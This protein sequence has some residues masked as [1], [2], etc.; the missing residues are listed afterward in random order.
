MREEGAPESDLEE[1]IAE[2]LRLTPSFETT[3]V[4]GNAENEPAPAKARRSIRR[5]FYSLQRAKSSTKKLE[6]AL[7]VVIATV[8]AALSAIESPLYEAAAIGTATYF[9][10]HATLKFAKSDRIIKQQNLAITLARPAAVRFNDILSYKGWAS[11]IAGIVTWAAVAA[12][13]IF[14]LPPQAQNG[15]GEF[16]LELAKQF[17]NLATEA[18]VGIASGFG[19]YVALSWLERLLHPETLSVIASKTALKL[20]TFINKNGAK[21]KRL[22]QIASAQHSKEGETSVLLQLGDEYLAAGHEAEA[23][24]AYKRMLKA[25][26]RKDTDTGVSDWL[27]VGKRFEEY[28]KET[29]DN[30]AISATYRKIRQAMRSFAAGN[31]ALANGILIELVLAEPENRQLRRL[32]ALF[33]QATGHVEP[34]GLEM[35]IYEELLRRD[36][37]LSFKAV[38]E[39]RNEVLVPNDETAQMPDVYVK[40]GRSM[41]SLEEEVNN[42]KAFSQE[43][44]GRVPEIIRQWSDGERHFVSLESLGSRTMLQKAISGKL[45]KQD[46][47]EVVDLLLDVI[48][49]G[50]KLERAGKIKLINPTREPQYVYSSAEDPAGAEIMK[51]LAI[52]RVQPNFSEENGSS[53]FV[54][55]LIDIFL[56]KTQ[57]YNGVVFPDEFMKAV[58]GG[59]RAIN[60]AILNHANGLW[61]TYSDF[62]HRNIMFN[63]LSGGVAGKID[64]ES[65]KLLPVLFELVNIFEFYHQNMDSYSH[66]EMTGYFLT[67]LEKKIGVKA[68]SRAFNWLYR[69]I[70]VQRHLELIGYMSRDAA[71]NESY[72]QAQA[73]DYLMAKAYLFRAQL[74]ST[75]PGKDSLKAML[76][77]LDSTPILKDA[78]LQ[79]ELELKARRELGSDL[80]HTVHEMG[81]KSY[82]Q[83]L[84]RLRLR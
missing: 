54:H 79:K 41:A 52:E 56:V 34:A 68:D 74:S 15:A 47:R 78:K 84:F 11:V 30:P 13:E 50:G 82:W 35:R 29:A 18:S 25:A 42:I 31:L 10:S 60:D 75:N 66:T 23:I 46:M 8:N 59:A 3:A 49:A 24:M 76:A 28:E 65:L 62:T 9:L 22:E 61:F 70:A 2:S 63:G 21:A 44:P 1:L 58:I 36:P 77:A 72:V 26:A 32:R 51:R 27:I 16:Y 55:R 38:G 53:Y 6:K 71:A 37:A 73:Y 19:T 33:Y 45:T 80:V 69:F 64:W 14:N 12:D 5:P 83:D 39:S 40:M 67:G 57:A 81:Q 20:Y 17:P 7:P 48:A 4:S 43:I